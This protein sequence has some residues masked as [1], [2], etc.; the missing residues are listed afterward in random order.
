MDPM[1]SDPRMRPSRLQP[2]QKLGETA[3]SLVSRIAANFGADAKT[4]C[5]HK[6]TSFLR[7]IKGDQHAF[8]KLNRYGVTIPDEV[9]SWSP[10]RKPSSIRELR[11][12]SFPSKVILS[13]EVRGCPVCL[14][15]DA[16][17]ADAPAHIAMAMRGNWLVPH[18]TFCLKHQHPLVPLWHDP[19][20]ASRYDS[21][22]HLKILTGDILSG[23][24]DQ[25]VREET[26]FEVWIE[27]RLRGEQ[28]NE[29][30]DQMPLH[31]AAN[32]CFMLGSALLR[33]EMKTPSSA[34]REDLWALYQMGYEVARH[35][36]SEVAIA[37]RKLQKLPGG[38]HDGP[39]KIF[40]ILYERLAYYYADNAD[41]EP[42]RKLLRQHMLETWPLGVGDEL[43]GEPVTERKV[44]SVLTAAQTTGVDQRRLRKML[45]AVDVV[46]DAESGL[47]DA[48]EVFDAEL[49]KPILDELTTLVDAKAF[50]AVIGATRSQFDTLAKDDVI[51]AELSR[52]D[53]K[54]IWNPSEGRKFL[55][56][57]RMGAV[58]LRHAKR[59]WVHLSKSAQRL[60]IGPGP[61]VRAIQE[62][63]I[64]K[65]GTHV[66]FV[67]YAAIYLDHDEVVSVLGTDAPDAA[68]IEVFAKTVGINQPSRMRRLI[69]NGHTPATLIQN[70]KTRA[71]QNYLTADDADAFH[72]KFMTPR[73]MAKEYGR[74]W[75]SLGA[76]M[77]S[78]GVNPFAPN[79]E[80]YGSLFLRSEVAT[81]LQ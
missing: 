25:E 32:F 36:Q 72:S 29:W 69:V 20:P 63:R 46:R 61:I 30:L 8:D 37:L 21:S 76:D 47:S 27:G 77:R 59:N 16:E 71:E 6:G 75:Q 81:A 50:A 14:R 58:Q 41:Y 24:F 66:S 34:A 73:T 3:A 26:D 74:S 48:W 38:P 43:L 31:P 68:S 5:Y 64:K 2:S 1:K 18:V 23:A 33:H 19:V 57:I 17:T 78:K 40:P 42:F 80:V 28:N 54:A 62:G 9:L 49:A 55:D 35:G 51:A 79:G 10:V 12:H 7:V 44:H 4:F 60:K 11:T 15:L 70:P 13:P 45:A 65:V 22:A 52:E 53:V 56:S 39:K 67:G